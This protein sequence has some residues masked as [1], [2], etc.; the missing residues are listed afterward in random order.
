MIPKVKLLPAKIW[1]SPTFTSWGNITAQSLRLFAVTPL[2][3]SNFNSIEISAWYLFGSI[4]LF[5][6]ITSTQINLLFS[7][8][9]ALAMGGATNLTPI[10][11]PRSSKEKLAPNWELIK[12]IYNTTGS[13]MLAIGA[14]GAIISAFLGIYGL[15]KMVVGSSESRA[16]WI[17]LS[18]MIAS[19]FFCSLFAKYQIALRGLNYISLTNRWNIAISL[20]STAAGFIS[21]TLGA[22][23]ISLTIVMQAI[24]TIGMFRFLPLL[25]RIED[26]RFSKFSG[27]GWDKEVIKESSRPFMK[28]LISTLANRSS[29]QFAIISFTRNGDPS[30]VAGVLLSMRL[31]NALG[32]ISAA[33]VTSRIPGFSRLIAEGKFANLTREFSRNIVIGLSLFSFGVCLLAI[34]LPFGIKYLDAELVPLPTRLFLMLATLMI[35]QQYIIFLLTITVMGNHFVFYTREVLSAILSIF[36]SLY[37]IPI[38]GI[39]GLLISAFVPQ[40]IFLNWL[41]LKIGA[42]YMHVSPGMLALRTAVI[43]F[44]ILCGCI[45]AVILFKHFTNLQ[46]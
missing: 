26:K 19:E 1:N 24:R 14:L 17:A 2:L 25:R 13:L 44:A 3:L 28:G 41:P 32:G 38:F 9:L 7:R 42:A 35:V 16:I 43:P 45:L 40:L 29:L 8:F 46:L 18:I 15:E 22:G 36:L 6:N 11:I 33:P 31:L 10:E 12:K 23:I 4:L 34:V 27:W 20:L 39:A 5:G 21:L 37:L 30:T